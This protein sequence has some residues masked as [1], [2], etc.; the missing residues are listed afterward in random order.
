MSDDEARATFLRLRWSDN[1]GQPYCPQCGC[2]TVYALKA[3]P[4]WKCGGCR[5][6]FSVTSGT[7][8]AD[9]KRPL[10]DYL[11]AIAVFVNGTKGHS[12]LQLTLCL[13][14]TRQRSSWRTSCASWS[15]MIRRPPRWTAPAT[16]KSTA[17]ISAAASSQRTKLRTA[18]IGVSP[19]SRPANGKSSS[20]PSEPGGRTLPFVVGKESAAIPMIRQHIPIGAT[21]HAD[22]ARGW[23]W[24]HAYFDMHRI[25]HS[26][27]YSKDGACTN[28]AESY[29][30]R[31][32]RS[33]IGI[34][35]RISGRYLSAYA[36]EMAWREDH[37]RVS[38]GAQFNVIAAKAVRS[39]V[40]A[41]LSRY[42]QRSAL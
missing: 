25:N 15:V 41:N 28:F 16:R 35:H 6:Q 39:P 40:S 42:W 27:A 1:E 11:L 24:L 20:S 5:L 31:A 29:F 13:A 30:S 19:R 22:E 21:V 7:I 3:R 17:P 33:E 38:N 23:D 9:R 12:A 37:R 18:S 8:F 32:R 10:R 2:A 14:S 26:E 34:H 36:T 4:V